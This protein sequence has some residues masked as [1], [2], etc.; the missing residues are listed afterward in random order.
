MINSVEFLEGKEQPVKIK[1][2]DYA[3]EV[4]IDFVFMKPVL[5]A[6]EWIHMVLLD[7]D[8]KDLG[9]GWVR[10]QKDGQLLISYSLLS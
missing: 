1:P 3:S 6:S 8:L 2:L 9:K 4:N 10:W 7:N 5:V